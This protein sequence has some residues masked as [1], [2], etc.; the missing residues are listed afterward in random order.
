[1]KSPERG[2]RE[3]SMG[4]D[5]AQNGFG[6]IETVVDNIIGGDPGSGDQG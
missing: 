1:M 6:T 4:K 5:V 2:R 3:E